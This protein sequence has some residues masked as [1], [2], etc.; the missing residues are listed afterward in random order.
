MNEK[1]SVHNWFLPASGDLARL[2]WYHRQGYDPS[3]KNENAIFA[4]ADSEMG[5]TSGVVNFTRFPSSYHWS[6]SES[7]SNDSW[8]VDFGDGGFSNG[9]KFGGYVVRPCVAF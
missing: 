9:Y 2:Y 3:E 4:K 7:S 1:F 8:Y 6:S 5:S